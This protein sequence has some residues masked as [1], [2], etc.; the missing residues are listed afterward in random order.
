LLSLQQRS[1]RKKELSAKLDRT[2]TISSSDKHWLDNDANTIDGQRVLD[3]LE[4]ALDYEQGF[5]QLDEDGKAIVKKLRE[6]AGE[7]AKDA[8]NKQKHMSFSCPRKVHH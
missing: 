1:R 8:G 5:E 3:T 2:E 6:W 7:L 4:P